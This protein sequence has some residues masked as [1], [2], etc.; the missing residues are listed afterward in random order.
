MTAAVWSRGKFM[1]MQVPYHEAPNFVLRMVADV[2]D[3]QSFKFLA[4][5]IGWSRQHKVWQD[6][7]FDVQARQAKLLLKV[8]IQLVCYPLKRRMSLPQVQG[9]GSL[10]VC[11]TWFTTTISPASS[12]FGAYWQSALFTIATKSRSQLINSLHH[13]CNRVSCFS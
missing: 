5:L 4:S 3:H 12:E 10:C 1:K 9:V 13:F 11:R 8:Y 2:V 6:H 7:C